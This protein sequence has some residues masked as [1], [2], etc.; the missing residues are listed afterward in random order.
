MVFD[1]RKAVT[2]ENTPALSI[3][4]LELPFQVL[5]VA[6]GD[7]GLSAAR[8]YDCYGWI[9]SQGKY[10]EITSTSNCTEFQAR[11]LDVRLRD[12]NGTRPLATLNG[13][14]CA[15]TRMI[16]LLLENH[17]QPDG[18]VRIPAALRPYLAGKESLTPVVAR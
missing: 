16:V 1:A 4:A 13:T 12:E 3:T 18:S 17:Q 11:R 15:M 10:R 6:S 5:E 9:P 8:K 2:L 7:L 14:L